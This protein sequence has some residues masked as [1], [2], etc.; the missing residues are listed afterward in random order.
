MLA[1]LMTT[2]PAIVAYPDE[3][4]TEVLIPVNKA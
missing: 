1:S 3:A 2:Q 4:L